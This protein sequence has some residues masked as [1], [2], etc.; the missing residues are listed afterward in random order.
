MTAG[1]KHAHH[2]GEIELS[3]R[4][5]VDFADHSPQQHGAHAFWDD[6]T[7]S[8]ILHT[9]TGHV[10]GWTLADEADTVIQFVDA[11]RLDE[12]LT[13]DQ[14]S[15]TL[16]DIRRLRMRLEAIENEAILYS[17]EY[18]AHT[19]RERE[20][21]GSRQKPRLT[22]TEVANELGLDH[23]TIVERHQRLTSG[24]HASWRPW[25]VQGTRRE[26]SYNG[27]RAV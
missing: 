23:S 14:M 3:R 6:G 1:D 20:P 16:T 27:T 10:H 5:G 7:T 22:V 17:R 18:S 12:D 25:L 24:R 8:Y 19:E 21:G 26:L 2:M 9:R 4:D 11:M 13:P 15:H